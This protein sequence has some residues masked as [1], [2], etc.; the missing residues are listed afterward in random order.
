MDTSWGVALVVGVVWGVTNTF[1]R[2][3]VLQAG[4]K[5]GQ[6]S[7]ISA[8]V[9]QHWAS[10]LSTPSFI[11]PQVVNWCASILMVVSLAGSKLHIATPVANGVSIAATAA[12]GQVLLRDNL[13]QKLLACGVLCIAAGTALCGS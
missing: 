11:V 10:L 6:H 2:M 7:R 5:T 3:G 4:E 9:G 8:L 12:S 1:V 13:D